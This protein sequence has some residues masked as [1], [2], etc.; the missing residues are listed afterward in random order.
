MQTGQL[1][2]ILA[3]LRTVAIFLAGFSWW[4]AWTHLN[5]SRT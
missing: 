1:K 5:K 2:R 4:L 3:D